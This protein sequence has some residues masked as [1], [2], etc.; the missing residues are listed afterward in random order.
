MSVDEPRKERQ[1]RVVED[2]RLCRDGEPRPDRD[3][4]VALDQHHP[5]GDGWLIGAGYDESSLQ[6]DGRSRRDHEEC[7][8][9]HHHFEAKR[10]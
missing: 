4:P 10:K 1:A 6:S 8:G 7:E 2:R 3:N 5:R 9:F